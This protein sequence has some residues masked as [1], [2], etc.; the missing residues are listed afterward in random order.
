MKVLCCCASGNTRSVTLAT[1]LKYYARPQHDALAC[2]VEKNSSETLE[3]LYGW[4]DRILT[5][6]PEI[7]GEIPEQHRAK[8][9][10]LMIGQDKWGM[11]MHPD[12]I[13]LA[14]QWL[15]SAGF[16]LREDTVEYAAQKGTKYALR[17]GA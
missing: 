1:L 7:Y 5:V 8:T 16:K 14:K 3:M 2:S 12:L 13:P 6:D 15:E 9:D 17:R 4:A 11:S 10:L